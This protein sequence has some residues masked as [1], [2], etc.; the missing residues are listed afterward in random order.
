MIIIIR[1]MGAER[2]HVSTWWLIPLVIKLTV[3]VL[4]PLLLS[5]K[6]VLSP[7]TPAVA[8]CP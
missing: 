8:S 3:A 1:L 4:V 2:G 6:T 7:P 5:S